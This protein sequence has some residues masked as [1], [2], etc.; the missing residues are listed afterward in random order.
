MDITVRDILNK[1]VVI[2]VTPG[3]TVQCLKNNIQDRWGIRPEAQRLIA[4]GVELT[5]VLAP[6]GD[7]GPVVTMVMAHAA[8]PQTI[9]LRIRTPAGQIFVVDVELTDTWGDVLRRVCERPEV[10]GSRVEQFVLYLCHITHH[11]L[12]NTDFWVPLSEYNVVHGDL[13][14]LEEISGKMPWH[15]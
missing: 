5:D 8:P 7:C 3:D 4:H 10:G 2:R 11:E 12:L 6:L 15:R 13:V 1:T 9:R 14:R